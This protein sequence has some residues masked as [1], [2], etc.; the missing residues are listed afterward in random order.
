[1]HKS[2]LLQAIGKIEANKQ[3]SKS[4]NHEDA[5]KEQEYHDMTIYKINVHTDQER[6]D[7][8]VW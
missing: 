2:M 3:I 1:M 7:D 6:H 8:D 5:I 4:I